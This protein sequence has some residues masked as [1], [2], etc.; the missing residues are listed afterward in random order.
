MR[1]ATWPGGKPAPSQLPRSDDCQLR[2]QIE[3]KAKLFGLL[4]D[5]LR[6][7][8]G[9]ETAKSGVNGVFEMLQFPELNRELVYSTFEALLVALFPEN[10]IE[11]AL[12]QL[13]RPE[14]D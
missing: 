7:L 13:R 4:P 11:T 2:T 10:R 8:I 5:E 3:A 1:E 9:S 14:V 12:A 6:T